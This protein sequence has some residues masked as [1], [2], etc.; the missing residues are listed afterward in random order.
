MPVTGCTWRSSPNAPGCWDR[1]EPPL[2]GEGLWR[3]PA[4]LGHPGPQAGSTPPG[5]G[6]ESGRLALGAAPF[7]GLVPSSVCVG[8]GGC[9]VDAGSGL[10]RLRRG[11]LHEGGDLLPGG[12][13]Y[14]TKAPPT[15]STPDPPPVAPDPRAVDD[16]RHPSDCEQPGHPLP[17][18]RVAAIEARPTHRCLGTGHEH[19]ALRRRGRGHPARVGTFLCGRGRSARWGTGLLSPTASNAPARKDTHPAAWNVPVDGGSLAGRGVRDARTHLKARDLHP[20]MP[21]CRLRCVFGN[22]RA[23]SS[24]RTEWQEDG[25]VLPRRKP[26]AVVRTHGMPEDRRGA[27]RR[28]GLAAPPGLTVIV[29]TRPHRKDV[30]GVPDQESLRHQPRCGN[31]DV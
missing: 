13:A 22:A 2:I 19:P 31:Q 27:S 11:L 16:R 5:R 29:T 15:R 20:R 1:G 30:T 23:R 9:G 7:P 3:E 4:G 17:G 28:A 8:S 25:R 12:C 6:G 14:C 10:G 18:R 26:G 24:A 21:Y